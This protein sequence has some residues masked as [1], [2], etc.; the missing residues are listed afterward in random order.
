MNTVK[1]LSAFG[2]TLHYRVANRHGRFVQFGRNPAI[3]SVPSGIYASPLLYAN[4]G[5]ILPRNT[6]CIENDVLG[7][8]DLANSLKVAGLIDGAMD[9]TPVFLIAQVF[10]HIRGW[11]QVEVVDIYVGEPD[12]S[13]PNEG[14]Y[15]GPTDRSAACD[16]MGLKRSALV[17][18][19]DTAATEKP[20][21]LMAAVA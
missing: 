15:L 14:V 2:Q 17:K 6:P 12:G 20:A 21:H 10:D 8:L 18:S 11:G 7:R 5:L 9:E 16:Q 3:T 4:V 1:L 13:E 19:W